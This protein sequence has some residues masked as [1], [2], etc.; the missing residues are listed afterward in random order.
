M[1]PSSDVWRMYL[2]YLFS[3]PDGLC[4]SEI[5]GALEHS[6]PT[7]QPYIFMSPVHNVEKPVKHQISA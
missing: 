6:V 4:S 5:H 1:K 7:Q 2:E 3:I